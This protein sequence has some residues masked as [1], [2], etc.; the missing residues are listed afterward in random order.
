MNGRALLLVFAILVAACSSPAATTSPSV[1]RSVAPASVAIVTPSPTATSAP[2]AA[3]TP[4]PD[5]GHPVGVIAIGH[6]GLTGEGTGETSVPNPNLSWATG[7][8]PAIESIY[9]R[10]VAA[11]PGTEG[12]VANTAKGGAPASELTSQAESALYQ[13][14]VPEL[15]IIQTVDNDIRCNASNVADVGASLDKALTLIHDRSP[16]TKIL[17]A[18]QLGRPDVAYVTSLVAAHPEA[19]SDLTW[20]DPCSFF[21]ADGK[22]RP[23]GFKNL[24]AAIDAYEAETAR[25]CAKVQN[26]A[27]DGGVRKAWR[28]RLELFASD[29]AH[30][31]A[32]GQRAEAENTWPA[33]AK[34]LGL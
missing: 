10:L 33:V 32:A 7:S 17:V 19:K 26:C 28:D 1:P 24:T 34:L 27:S 13:V 5:L 29:W 2:T 22:L 14:P 31:N 18:G 20:D 4:T 30:L 12:H 8:D 3:P 23:E 6:S 15:A 25:V 21:G 9:L 11:H 16:K